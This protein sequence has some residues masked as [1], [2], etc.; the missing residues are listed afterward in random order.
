MRY[1]LNIAEIIVLSR[2]GDQRSPL[3]KPEISIV[4]AYLWSPVV[5]SDILLLTIFH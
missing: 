1:Q 2:A 3:Q 5:N 4:G